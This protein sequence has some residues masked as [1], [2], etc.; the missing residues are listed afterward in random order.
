MR[1]LIRKILREAA[2]SRNFQESCSSDEG[3]NEMM[4]TFTIWRTALCNQNTF[5]NIQELS[6]KYFSNSD[7]ITVKDEKT[8][9]VKTYKKSDYEKKWQQDY[10]E[11][12]SKC[13]EP[14]TATEGRLDT[15]EA[16][17]NGIILND[18][19]NDILREKFNSFMSY[20]QRCHALYP[21]TCVDRGTSFEDMKYKEVS[22][23]NTTIPDTKLKTSTSPNLSQLGKT[24]LT[25]LQKT[26]RGMDKIK[27][28]L[29]YTIHKVKEKI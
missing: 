20:P 25:F 10:D 2:E 6:K 17:S 21:L 22:K 29:G 28:Y 15:K 27:N 19:E 24:D 9:E 18:Y 4:K 16:C 3:I 5:P 23:L 12:L 7:T 11:R 8:G 13:G 26:R 1:E 14:Y